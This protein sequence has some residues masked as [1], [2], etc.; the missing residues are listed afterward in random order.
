VLACDAS[1]QV[2]T[3]GGVWRLK[4]HPCEDNLLLAAC[5]YNGFALVE[6]DQAWDRLQ[7]RTIM[8]GVMQR[9]KKSTPKWGV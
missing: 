2:A 6:V 7:V 5:M 1:V 8:Q 4:W 3:G 9:V